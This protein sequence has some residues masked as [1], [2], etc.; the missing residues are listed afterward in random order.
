MTGQVAVT[1]AFLPMIRAARGRIVL[2]RSIG[3]RMSLPYLFSLPRLQVRARGD[4]RLAARWRWRPFGVSV[5]IIE[6][7][8]IKTPFWGK[9][10]SQ[11]DEILDAMT[12]AQRQLYES[13]GEGRGRGVAQGARSEASPPTGSR[14]RS[15][16]RSPPRGPKTR[17]LVG[18]DARI[19]AALQKRRSPTGCS[20]AWSR[21]SSSSPRTAQARLALRG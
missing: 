16:T 4:R 9:G 17:Y 2:M 19:Q 8:S 10:T 11:V 20:T 18:I 6:P 14:R 1:Q 3:G 15:S 5:S 21:A 7:G 13:H 12:P